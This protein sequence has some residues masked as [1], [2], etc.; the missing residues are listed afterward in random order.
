MAEANNS[1]WDASPLAPARPQSR[2]K[3]RRGT[4]SCWECKRRKIR[5]AFAS[6]VDTICTGCQRRG[7][8]C[9]SQDL[10]DHPEPPHSESLREM[11]SRMSR[12]EA[13]IERLTAGLNGEPR[14]SGVSENALGA[15]NEMEIDIQAASRSWPTAQHVNTTAPVQVLEQPE[16]RND[17][18][19]KTELS[20]ICRGSL[21]STTF[22]AVRAETQRQDH[23]EK[24]SRI[25]DA[26]REA[27]PSDHDLQLIVNIPHGA[28]GLLHAIVDKPFSYFSTQTP[29]S[30]REILQLPSST[31]HPI[32]LAHK[33]LT[34]ASFLQ[35]IPSS[36]QG[37]SGLST[38]PVD[39]MTRAV[40]AAV[41]LVVSDDDLVDS[42]E[43]IEC[44]MIYSL[45][46]NNKGNLRRAWV[47]LRRAMTLAQVMGL[48]QGAHAPL[49]KT[50]C[51]ETRHRINPEHMW[52]RL[53]Q[54]DQ[55][56]SLVLGLPPACTQSGE[57]SDPATLERCTAAERMERLDAVASGHILRRNS[58][59]LGN[60]NATQEVDE[61]LQRASECMP[62]QWWLMPDLAF[63]SGDGMQVFRDTVR[64]TTQFTHYTL[65]LHLHLPYVLCSSD[66]QRYE[67]SKINAA[68]ASREILVRYLA[69]RDSDPTSFYCRGIEFIAFIACTVLSLA[70]IQAHC[71][72]SVSGEHNFHQ[73]RGASFAY[74]KHQR[75]SDRGIMERVL[76]SMDR[77]VESSDDRIASKIAG[78]IRPLL[79]IEAKAAHGSH[80]ETRS[81]LGMKEE[82]LECNGS[83]C[84]DDSLL[85][86]YIPNTGTVDIEHCGRFR[87]TNHPPATMLRSTSPD[88][89]RADLGSACHWPS[90]GEQVNGDLAMHSRTCTEP[91]SVVGV[92]SLADDWALQGVDVALFDNLFNG[93][94]MSGV[95]SEDDCTHFIGDTSA[96]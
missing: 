4:I 39:I 20:T 36:L 38:S 61:I 44:I 75:L 63:S 28:S 53:N 59:D 8:K 15:S 69:I 65:L 13:L 67:Q 90:A 48:H 82:D 79:A 70:H 1:Q 16:P 74:L 14:T 42:V 41:K 27:W 56:L 84:E 5:C 91:S 30:P 76:E 21:Q 18:T 93:V 83:L 12:M 62:P 52:R 26:L 31:S 64:I 66:D 71:R 45:Y 72:P 9:I 3:I 50:A 49:P 23:V 60:F 25:S 95:D 81:C 47:I 80:Y 88:V 46:E 58:T 78:I 34:L 85:H 73:I 40:D 54:S 94:A 32:V 57:L 55:Y 96:G 77:M 17:T 43:G 87:S 2:R 6:P 19:D 92:A 22:V 86:I 11:G 89:F 24:Y 33:L 37:L 7:T 51:V 35:C 29:P 68:T 10:P